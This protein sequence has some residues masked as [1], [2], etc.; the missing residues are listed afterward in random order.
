MSKTSTKVNRLNGVLENGQEVSKSVVVAAPNLQFA[1]FLIKGIAP[2]VQNKFSNKAKQQIMETQEKGS[3]AKSKKKRDPKNFE[4]CYQ[5][6]MYVSREGWKGIP[7]PSFRSAMIEACRL[8]GFKMTHAKLSVFV[9]A[10]GFDATEGT[11]LVKIIGEPHRHDGP[12]RLASGV[13]DIRSRPMWDEWSAWVRIKFDADQFSP[14]DVCNLLMR[15]G[16]QVGIGEGRP[17][18]RDSNGVG[19]GVFEIVTDAKKENKKK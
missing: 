19:W 9:E 16:Q 12:V 6:A 15:A 4:E 2:Y 7:A 13:L 17:N 5:G 3:Q 18:S 14:D 1:E 11:P 10:D 8:V